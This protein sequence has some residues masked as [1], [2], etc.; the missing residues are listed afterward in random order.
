MLLSHVTEQV[1]NENGRISASRNIYFIQRVKLKQARKWET[2][3]EQE[4]LFPPWR[5]M[6]LAIPGFPGHTKS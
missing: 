1:S 4:T 2:E 6:R 5:G 3:L